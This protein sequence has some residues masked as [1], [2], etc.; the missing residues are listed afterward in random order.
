MLKLLRSSLLLLLA[1][2]SSEPVGRPDFVL[3]CLDTL[4]ADRLGA[5]GNQQGLTPN[6]DRF[7]SEALVFEQA[8]ALANETL[9]SH[10]AL[11]TSLYATETG[12]IFDS[13]ALAEGP[14]TLAEV[15]GHYGYQSG[16]AV[17][18][19]HMTE[20]FG[21][22]RGFDSWVS[23]APWGSLYHSVPDALAWLD[24]ADPE[25]PFLLFLHG[26]DT[27]HRYLKPAPYGFALVENT[28]Q[29]HAQHVS[30]GNLGTLLVADGH[31][32][33][34]HRPEDLFDF[35]ALRIRGAEERARIARYASQRDARAQRFTDE[36]VAFIR[37]VYDGAAMYADAHFGLFMAALEERGHL[38]DSY[39]IVLADHGEELGEDGIFN[40]R[41]TL[42][43]IALRVPLMIRPPGGFAKG[44][45]EVGLW[46]LSDLLPTLLDLIDAQPPAGIRGRSLRPL[47]EGQ[48]LQPRQAVFSQTM[49]RGVSLRTPQ[50]RVSFTG[51][52]ADSPYLADML[53]TTRLDGPAFSASAGLDPQQREAMRQ[54]LAD[55][56]A[57]LAQP[58]IEAAP[59]SDEQR[60]VIQDKG[61]WGAQ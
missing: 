5:Y 59:I 21:L 53:R 33:P 55:W 36:D 48:P 44:R 58:Q 37:G 50:G 15:L 60:R 51:I 8:Y 43:D 18:G 11:F 24:D 32:F 23:S 7:A 52:G 46:D 38:D 12:P 16:A 34:N 25:R 49:F 28:Y 6:L 1:A 14:P 19:G 42:S 2:C 27:H 29:G 41:Y 20:A 57:G 45:R 40:H 9:Y 56:A 10:A 17:G 35:Q 22:G 54:Q 31:L 4:R 47:L 39:V 26:Y 13:F 61:Y 30:R 3:V